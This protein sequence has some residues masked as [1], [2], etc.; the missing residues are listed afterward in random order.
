MSSPSP[1]Q[2][3]VAQGNTYIDFGRE[4]DGDA[5]A[6]PMKSPRGGASPLKSPRGSAEGKGKKSWQVRLNATPPCRAL[7]RAGLHNV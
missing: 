1:T 4:H 5:M 2:G 3:E 7:R 6:T